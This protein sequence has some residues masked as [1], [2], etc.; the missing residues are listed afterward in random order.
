MSICAWFVIIGGIHTPKIN[1]FLKQIKWEIW[2][3]EV[4]TSLK[5]CTVPTTVSDIKDRTVFHIP[6]LFI[7]GLR[8]CTSYSL[9]FQSFMIVYSIG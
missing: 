9:E 5:I 2:Y 1:S 3:T 7:N 4:H 8:W 6:Y